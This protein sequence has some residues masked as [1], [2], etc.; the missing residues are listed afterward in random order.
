M[1]VL[2]H[3]VLVSATINTGRQR[4]HAGG[5]NSRASIRMSK[6]GDGD[7][8]ISGREQW[9]DAANTLAIKPG[10]VITYERNFITNELLDK[11]GVKVIALEGSELLRGRGG[12]RCMSMPITRE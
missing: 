8:V 4:G 11:K 10:T 5:I 7:K 12:P 9:N 6:C 3:F 1:F 2:L